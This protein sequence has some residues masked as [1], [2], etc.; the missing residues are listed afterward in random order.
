MSI[1]RIDPDGLFQMDGFSQVVTVPAGSRLAF[2]A[3]QGAFDEKMQLVGAGDLEAQTVQA[4]TNLRIAVEAVGSRADQIVSSTVHVVGLDGEA[5]GAL[6]RGL[7]RG[8][9]G[10]PFPKHAMSVIGTTGLAMDGMLIEIVAT[11]AIP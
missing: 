1:E 8:L 10:K 6:A 3:G 9:D 7:A 5:V 4:L 11:A 2:I